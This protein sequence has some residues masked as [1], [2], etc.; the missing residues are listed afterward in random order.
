MRRREKKTR[1]ASLWCQRWTPTIQRWL[2]AASKSTIR[3]HEEKEE[4]QHSLR[5]AERSRAR[6]RFRVVKKLVPRDGWRVEL[7]S[8]LLSGSLFWGAVTPTTLNTQRA[9][10]VHVCELKPIQTLDMLP[11]DFQGHARPLR[12]R[13]MPTSHKPKCPGQPRAGP[14]WTTTPRRPGVPGRRVISHG[15]ACASRTVF[16]HAP[17]TRPL[18]DRA[19]SYLLRLVRRGVEKVIEFREHSEQ[20]ERAP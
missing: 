9:R 1:V 6:G 13:Q 14:L 15:S 4:Q 20:R 3:E 7:S 10:P 5:P 12:R 16:R 11:M 8:P 19:I 2:R 18:P 17:R